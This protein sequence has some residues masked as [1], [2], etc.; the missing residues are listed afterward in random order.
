MT[1]RDLIAQLAPFPDDARIVVFCIPFHFDVIDVE[2]IKGAVSLVADPNPADDPQ[3]GLLPP[4][5]NPASKR[6]VRPPKG[7]K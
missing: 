6:G 4:A 1:K 2:A 5:E 3:G 7:T